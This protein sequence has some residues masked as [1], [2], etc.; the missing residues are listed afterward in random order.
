MLQRL[1]AV[2]GLAVAALLA[3][4]SATAG[5]NQY[6]FERLWPVLQ[7]PWYFYASGLAVDDDGFIY[8]ADFTA[9]R[10]QKFTLQGQYITQWGTAGDGPG[11]FAAPQSV[12]VDSSG[13]VYVADRSNNRVQ[14][15]TSNGE[16]LTEFG[17]AGSGP[18]EISLP[19]FIAIDGLDAIYALELGNSRV[20]KFVP[21]VGDDPTVPHTYDFSFGSPGLGPGEF[22]TI[23]TALVSETGQIYVA[24]HGGDRIQRF[25][26]EGAF[27]L[28]F[29]SFGNGP[30]EFVNPRGLA[31]TAA[32]ELLVGDSNDRIQVFDLDGNYVR[33]IAPVL[34]GNLAAGDIDILPSGELVLAN[35]F[36]GDIVKTSQS[37]Q[38]Q[39]IFSSQGDGP[40][41]FSG[42]AGLGLNPQGQIVT[43]E[44]PGVGSRFQVFDSDGRYLSEFQLAENVAWL[45]YRSDGRL[46][47]LNGNILNGYD[48]AAS[49]LPEDPPELAFSTSDLRL[50]DAAVLVGNNG[51]DQLLQPDSLEFGTPSLLPLNTQV[52]VTQALAHA[53]L[54]GDGQTDLVFGRDGENGLL[55]GDFPASAN[56][57]VALNARTDNTRALAMLDADGNGSL[58]IVV[59]NADAQTRVLINNGTGGFS[60]GAALGAA[61]E[62]TQALAVA[63]VDGN[64]TADIFVGNAGTGSRIH[65]GDGSGSF[66]PGP[67]LAAGTAINA[68]GFADLDRDGDPDLVVGRNGTNQVYLNDAGVLGA[69]QNLTG[70]A[71]DTR[72]LG[73]A[74][75]DLDGFADVVVGNFN[76]VNRYYLNQGGGSPWTG[77]DL[78][79]DAEPTTALAVYLDNIFA[80]VIAGNDGAPNRAHYTSQ[81]DTT[82]PLSL[83]SLMPDEGVTGTLA[84]AHVP[85]LSAKRLG[86][87]SFAT[88]FALSS[89]NQLY[90]T[91]STLRKIVRFNQDGVALAESRLPFSPGLE[92]GLFG[93]VAVDSAE[94]LFVTDFFNNR[95]HRFVP[96]AS[97]A[98][99]DPHTLDLTFGESGTGPGQLDGAGVIEVLDNGNLAITDRQDR[100]QIFTPDGQFVDSFGQFGSIPGAF[101]S[102]DRIKALTD[103]RLV[104]TDRSFN[105]VQTFR[106]QTV[107]DNTKVIMVAGGGPYPGNALWDA[108]QNNANFAYR[109]L[110][111]QG[112][113]RDTIFYLSDDTDLDL[114][115][116]GEADDVDGAAT[117]ANLQ[118]A[119]A[120]FAADAENLIV[121]LIDHGGLDTFRISGTE[122]LAAGEL[123][124]LLDSWQ[125]SDPGRGATLIYDACQ[126]GSFLEE[127]R[128]ELYDRIVI[129]SSGPEEN[130]YFV[131]QGALSFSNQFWTHIFN[132][133]SIEDAFNLASQTQS[134]SFP[135][136]TPL[137]DADGDGMVNTTFDL[138]RLAGRFIGNGTQIFGEVPEVG[139]VSV[140]ASSGSS[141]TVSATSVTDD[142]G[143]GRVWMVLRPPGFNPGSPDNPV[144]DLPTVEL[145]REAGTDNF[146]A[147]YNNFTNAGTY[148]ITVYAQDAVGNTAV[149]QVTFLTIDNPLRRKAI[150]VAAGEAAD[151]EAGPIRVN[152]DLAYAA[153]L[154]QGY[155][156]D[157]TSCT[158]TLCDDVQYLSNIGV[159][160]LDSAAILSNL[161]F[162][163]TDWALRDGQDLV[164]YLVGTPDAGGL[165]L[166]S[167]EV[168]TA[169]QLNEW[170]D[171]AGAALPG[172]L[173]VVY[174]GEL[175]GD[176]LPVLAPPAGE[177]R[178]VIVTDGETERCNL[179]LDESLSFSRYFW[180][181]VLNG[182][183]VRQAFN[184]ARQGI[185]FSER[186][187]QAQL[188]DNGNGVPNEFTDGLLA[189]NFALGSGVLLA[190]DEPLVASLSA[191][192]TITGVTAV[193]LVA[194][195][196]TS[197]GTIMAVEAVVTLPSCEEVRLPMQA[198]GNGR[199]SVQTQIF[200]ELS[201]FHDVAVI[202]RDDE[203]LSSLP[204]ATSIEQ[205]SGSLL[206]SD[207]F[208]SVF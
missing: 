11:E 149:P 32:D 4:G 92:T 34:G 203:G 113:T 77:V 46:Y 89:Q 206:F 103:G 48:P 182:A 159:A 9:A 166:N 179:V 138:A 64:G 199:Y 3:S 38:V 95:V 85:D 157:G 171:T 52:A 30:G 121:Y 152:A 57:T 192:D 124:A 70:D 41:R 15:F 49:G 202:A 23:A 82:S 154:Q 170:L 160:G 147:T 94:R 151:D 143:I 10:I 2:A 104:T 5:A 183:T 99:T 180:G 21:P 194:E 128:S 140:T 98:G 40:G 200:S 33:E 80:V 17:S 132:G 177:E 14:K 176:F 130:A 131:S 120:N 43:T 193:D 205:L 168:L 19:R 101:G 189:R 105:R 109:V 67:E 6:G 59:G 110:V 97:L 56:T 108:T 54:D 146:A 25:S 115:G 197:T 50:P 91:D 102:I 155:G 162:A 61:G 145:A 163:I 181:Q 164:V 62:V 161:E 175:S 174:D 28:E 169:P 39:A 65:F 153:L 96:P 66:T 72:A 139:S 44:N 31:V 165:R 107:V 158:Q 185:R 7:Q 208:E 112:F 71:H 36:T 74:D 204:V 22:T 68:A 129:A 188:D 127:T 8:L 63:D 106:P 134:T 178:I 1:R 136:Q 35:L 196:V 12:V 135:E 117:V 73:F 144:Q 207:S 172:P 58:D 195:G 156:P 137:V 24:S 84:L 26:A 60:D 47:T 190:G 69:P 37:G 42:I 79:S 142:D 114:D 119:F 167:A 141:A 122:T 186:S 75:I 118:S 148:Q 55:L 20:S 116:N 78:S 87:L 184:L 198:E 187:Q 13:N 51:A 16:Y 88:T 83:T 126:S 76:Q 133:L 81:F 201:G 86:A 191:P 45:A 125:S 90:V 18:G 93:A 29:G 100:V 27:E 150:I 123:G 173:V 111:S 53:D